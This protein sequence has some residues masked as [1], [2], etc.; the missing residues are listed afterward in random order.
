[1][2]ARVREMEEEASKL[3]E[4]QAEVEKTMNGPEEGQFD[5]LCSIYFEGL[6]TVGANMHTCIR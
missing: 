4:M 3:R 5:S 2:K 6:I 1:M